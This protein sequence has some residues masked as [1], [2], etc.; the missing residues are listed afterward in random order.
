MSTTEIVV[1]FSID[2]LLLGLIVFLTRKTKRR[3]SEKMSSHKQENGG[4]RKDD[5]GAYAPED[6]SFEG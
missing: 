1:R 2:I 6:E 4:E 5:W 3:Q